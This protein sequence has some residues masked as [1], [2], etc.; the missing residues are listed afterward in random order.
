MD[1]NNI[2]AGI[3]DS[4][5]HYEAE[6]FDRDRETLLSA[7]LPA[8]GVCGVINMGSDLKACFE[9]VRL[10]EV[11]RY[12]YGAVGIHPECASELPG[13]W[14]ET[15]RSLLTHDKIV[16]IGEIGLDYHWLEACPKERQQEV[17]KA[18][19]AL[20]KEL[21]IP[22]VIHDREAHG[23]IM[24]LLQE[25]RPRGVMHCFSGS[26]ELSREIIK[27]G[28]YI[29]LGGVI[30]FKN[31][32]HAVEVAADIPLNRLLLET[33]APY[34][35]PVPYRGKRNDS[36]LIRYVA[37]KIAE[38][39]GITIEAVLNAAAE[40]TRSLFGIGATKL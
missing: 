12:F 37:E 39:R 15:V 16:A 17:F 19:L 30:T 1:M 9:T 8:A 26:V 27:L 32:R 5:A 14:L 6:E 22:V 28:M 7:V 31:A 33:D 20:S 25:Y 38:I 40:N 2:D 24:E 29:G 34:M 4:H 3:F 23:D 13:D 36:S 18:Q 35:A 10:T 21:D 11:Y